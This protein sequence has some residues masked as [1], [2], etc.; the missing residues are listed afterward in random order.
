MKT[1]RLYYKKTGPVRPARKAKVKN[2]EVQQNSSEIEN[3]SPDQIQ[4]LQKTIGNQAVGSLLKSGA[5]Q[6]KLTVGQPGDIHEQEADATASKVMSMSVSQVQRQT[7]EEEVQTASMEEEEVQTSPQEEEVQTSPDEEEV[8]TSPDEEEMQMSPEDE[9]IQGKGAARPSGLSDSVAGKI[10]NMKGG[11]QPLSKSARAFFEPRFGADFSNV[12]IHNS[13][14]AHETSAAI[15]AKAYTLGNHIAFGK[16]QYS[17]ESSEGKHLMAHELTHVVQQGGAVQRKSKNNQTIRRTPAN[18]G[19]GVRGTGNGRVFPANWAVTVCHRDFDV[20]LVGSLVPARHTYVWFHAR[21]TPGRASNIV[22]VHTAT[23]DNS[24]NGQPD[25]RPRMSG[26]ACTRTFNVNPNT[27]MAGYRRYSPS[28]Y[29]LVT[30]NCTTVAN[31]AL[32]GAG[33][34]T[35]MSDFP[36]ASQGTGLPGRYG[37]GWKKRALEWIYTRHPHFNRT[38]I[39]RYINNRGQVVPSRIPSNLDAYTASILCEVLIRGVCNSTDE[40]AVYHIL[41]RQSN[42]VFRGAV[43]RLTLNL[44]DS[45]LDGMNWKRFAL[46]CITK[47]YK[48]EIIRYL[49]RD[50]DDDS[51][52][53]I[54]NTLHRTGRMGLLNTNQWVQ[55]IIT[56][57]TGTC[58]DADE[59]A[60]LRIFG[61]MSASHFRTA[62]RTLT[63]SYIDSGLDGAEWRLFQALCSRHGVT[64]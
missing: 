15:Q 37:T 5:L 47:G 40:Q 63:P 56:L 60:I 23:Y 4:A 12:K 25:P 48:N 57:I 19:F 2:T 7:D 30:L 8:Q 64:L 55:M 54:T 20:P 17:P 14:T 18:R 45:G 35:I 49:N 44:I 41:S 13:S 27:V 43:N 10:Q 51:A 32:R 36:A 3:Q 16:G 38:L 33:A 26:T 1:I 53:Y 9:E 6:P 39:A 46:L 34:A 58:S 22:G 31:N 62:V 29:N 61:S 21:S 50:G 42:A 11:G 24:R 59:Q 52:R 28:N